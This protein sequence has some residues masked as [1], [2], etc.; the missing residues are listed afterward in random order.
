MLYRKHHLKRGIVVEADAVIALMEPP[1][2][3]G[4]KKTMNEI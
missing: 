2:P 1:N 3:N 4:K